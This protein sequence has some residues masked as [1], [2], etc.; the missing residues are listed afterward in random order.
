MEQSI[1]P[2]RRSNF[3]QFLQNN[4][5]LISNDASKTWTPP[6]LSDFEMHVPEKDLSSFV[7]HHQLY[8]WMEDVRKFTPDIPKICFPVHMAG[9]DVVFCLQHKNDENSK[10]IVAIQVSRLYT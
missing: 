8:K 3:L 1:S 10:I 4:L 9:P 2:E 6:N 7:E 5:K